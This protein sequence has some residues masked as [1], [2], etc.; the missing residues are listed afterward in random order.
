MTQQLEKRLLDACK[1][2]LVDVETKKFPLF[3]SSFSQQ[4]KKSQ[5]TSD[6]YLESL[7]KL[8][9]GIFSMYFQF[10][11][12]QPFG[13]LATWK[14]GRRTMLPED[15]QED[16]LC[17]LEEIVQISDNPEFVARISDVLWIRRRN[18]L[19]AKKMKFAIAKHWEEEARSFQTPQGCDGLNLAHRLEQAIYAYREAGERKKAEELVYE[20]KE[21][22]KL[23]LSQMKVISSP[24]IDA[25]DLIKIADDLLK[26][27]TGVAA[28]EGFAALCKP[29][30]Y[31]QEKRSA[32]KNLKEHPLQGLFDTK[33]LTEEG[34]V[35]AKISGV[36]DDYENTLKSIL[37]WS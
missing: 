9:M 16:E 36:T 22:N 8:L 13:P 12:D 35:S 17:K 3:D 1:E 27:K 2:A 34:N 18:P 5:E 29:F 11:K 20:L 23:S 28:I 6:K 31:E 32:E 25:T 37:F 10:A 24:P 7:M 26:G 19:Y 14:D 4:L 30:S 33:I 21:A 15:L